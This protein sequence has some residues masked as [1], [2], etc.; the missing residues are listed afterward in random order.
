M[1]SGPSPL[2]ISI[3][4]SMSTACPKLLL[5]EAGEFLAGRLKSGAKP[6]KMW[7]AF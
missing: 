5:D 4:S 3:S 7:P 2:S 6:A 1:F